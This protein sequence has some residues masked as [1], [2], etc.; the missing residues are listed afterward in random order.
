MTNKKEVA[1]KVFEAFWKNEPHPCNV[2]GYEIA[3]A[4]RELV[5][6]LQY[7]QFKEDVEDMVL[8]ARAILDVCDELEN[9]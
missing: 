2:D 7:Y 9:L 4:L 8:D 3:N 1:Q 6:E 5:A